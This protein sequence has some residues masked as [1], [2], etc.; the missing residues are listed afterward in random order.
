MKKILLLVSMLLMITNVSFAM[1]GIVEVQ[2][3][4]G[5]MPGMSRS[6]V[7][8]AW[9]E[10]LAEKD[11]FAYFKPGGLQ[12]MFRTSDNPKGVVYLRDITAKNNPQLVLQPSGI[13]IGMTKDEIISRLGEPDRISYGHFDDGSSYYSTDIVIYHTPEYINFANQQGNE[14]IELYVNVDTNRLVA[15][16]LKGTFNIPFQWPTENTKTKVKNKK[17]V[18]NGLG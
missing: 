11:V 7:L 13:A 18:D 12:A 1:Q 6:E 9:G 8:A 5:V 2:T 14:D 4:N 3:I 17:K 10:P 16:T 15:I